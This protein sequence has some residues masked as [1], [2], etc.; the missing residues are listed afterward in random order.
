MM[1]KNSNMD[2]KVKWIWIICW[3][4]SLLYALAIISVPILYL[5][6]FKDFEAK[7]QLG[8]FII[9]YTVSMPFRL[10]GLVTFI[11][12]I[13]NL[14]IWHKRN[15]RILNLLLLLF[16]NILYTPVYYYRKEVRNVIK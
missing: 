13:Y 10:A 2:S 1:N 7:Q 8:K 16:L 9:E 6:N 14:L 4:I 3:I 12:W 11:F 15:D 5:F